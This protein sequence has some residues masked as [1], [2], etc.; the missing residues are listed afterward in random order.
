VWAQRKIALKMIRGHYGAGSILK[1]IQAFF[2]A[3][4]KGVR[5]RLADENDER[6]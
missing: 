6:V 5:I 3:V 2:T 4:M 1:G